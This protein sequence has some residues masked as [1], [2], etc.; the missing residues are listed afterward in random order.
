[1][2]IFASIFLKQKNQKGDAQEGTFEFPLFFSLFFDF[3]THFKFGFV[4]EESFRSLMHLM[5]YFCIIHR[6]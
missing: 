6:V 5:S 2:C 3:S 1:M 4:V